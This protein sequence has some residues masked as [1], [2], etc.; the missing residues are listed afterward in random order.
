MKVSPDAL[1]W[2]ERVRILPLMKGF[3]SMALC[4]GYA[5]KRSR[6]LSGAAE[7]GL[8]TKMRMGVF[9]W[10]MRPQGFYSP[11]HTTCD[12]LVQTLAQLRNQRHPVGHC[13]CPCVEL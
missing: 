11:G 3:P 13:A 2:F 9:A 6:S 7:P 1:A 8:K 4:R 12:V 10:A 5:S